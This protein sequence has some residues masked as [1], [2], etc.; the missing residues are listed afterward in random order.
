MTLGVLPIYDDCPIGVRVDIALGVPGTGSLKCSLNQRNK[1]F[2]ERNTR[3]R[4][5]KP[6]GKT[7]INSCRT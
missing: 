1:E 5:L 2:T 7:V 6:S 4:N 3:F